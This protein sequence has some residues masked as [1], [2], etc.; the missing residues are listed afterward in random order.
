MGSNPWSPRRSQAG[1][2]MMVELGNGNRLFFDFG[3]GCLR[4]IV[5]NQVPVP[6]INDIFITHLHIDHFSDLPYVAI[7]AIQ[8][9]LDAAARDRTVRSHESAR[10]TGDVR[11][12]AE[13][14]RVDVPV[15]RRADAERLPDRRH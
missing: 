5:A 7:R 9:A 1:T 12:P 15:G 4:N 3:L 10:H 2:C 11:A 13:D 8:R 14:G 6:E